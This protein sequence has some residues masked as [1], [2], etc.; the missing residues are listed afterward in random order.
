MPRLPAANPTCTPAPQAPR[1]PRIARR[2]SSSTN[3]P[4]LDEL[5]H[6]GQIR[7]L[8]LPP[9]PDLDPGSDEEEDCV[10]SRASSTTNPANR[11]P[12][13]QLREHPAQ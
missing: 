13:L 1:I 4:P 7:P 5:F 2:S 12:L 8:T 3:R 11:P 9:L 10:G 6:N